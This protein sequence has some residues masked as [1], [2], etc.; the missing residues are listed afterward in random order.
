MQ[1]DELV[2]R[3]YKIIIEKARTYSERNSCFNVDKVQLAAYFKQC[4][5]DKILHEIDNIKRLNDLIF[6]V[7]FK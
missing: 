3:Y 1:I 6:E 2:K 4:D 7:F 5:I